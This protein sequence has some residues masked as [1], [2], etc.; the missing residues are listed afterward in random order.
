MPAD[1]H[2]QAAPNDPAPRPSA[3]RA[4]QGRWGQAHL[5]GPGGLHSVLAAMAL[6]GAWSF[7][8]K[9]LA[10]V[11]VNNGAKN[12]G[13]GPALR[14]PALSGATD[15]VGGRVELKGKGGLCEETALTLNARCSIS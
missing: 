1:T 7:R 12:T 2:P 13:R 14:Y 10:A 3:T 11:E 6:F 5:L 4:R 15:A 9:D 8:A